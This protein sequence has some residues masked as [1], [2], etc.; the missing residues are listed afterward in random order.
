MAEAVDYISSL[1]TSVEVQVRPF[2]EIDYA[3]LE[4]GAGLGEGSY[5]A[6]Y[7]GKWKSKVVAIKALVTRFK[8]REVCEKSTMSFIIYCVHTLSRG[9]TVHVGHNFFAYRI[10][11]ASQVC[12]P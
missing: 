9:Q 6:V 11:V 2:V 8:D 12:I 5:G 1:E 3:E 10:H 4:F 7:K